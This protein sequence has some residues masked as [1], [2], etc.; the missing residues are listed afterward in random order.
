MN[1]KEKAIVEGLPLNKTE[2]TEKE[3]TEIITVKWYLDTRFAGCSYEGEFKINKNTPEED[4]ERQV[5]E[6][7][8]NNIEWGW[9]RERDKQ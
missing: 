7:A 3:V 2:E 6:E 4:I 8:L 5:K 9:W 1:D